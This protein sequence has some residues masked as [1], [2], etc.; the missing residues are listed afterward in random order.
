M[1]NAKGRTAKQMAYDARRAQMRQDAAQAQGPD[2]SGAEVSDETLG[3]GVPDIAD[4]TSSPAF[5]TAVADAVRAAMAERP[6]AGQSAA[7]YADFMSN[8]RQLT[9]AFQVQSPGFNKPLPPEE[10]AR[11]SA[12][13]ET[14]FRL[15]VEAAEAV[16]NFGRQ[17]AAKR[18]LV[19]EYLVGSGGILADTDQ[20]EQMFSPGQRLFYTQAPPKDFLPLNMPAGEIMHAQFQWLGMPTPG[21]EALVNSAVITANGGDPNAEDQKR[22]NR[23][24][25]FAEVVPDSGI[26]SVGPRRIL[27]AT[28]EE[29]SDNGRGR[30]AITKGQVGRPVTGPVFA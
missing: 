5:R 12:G 1:A 9:E 19:P 8:M 26:V 25:Q 7:D 18:D 21:A 10:V 29:S 17:G 28:V 14:F 15:I 20:G 16:E 27:G 24:S 6:P 11:R 3:V 4:I 22:A 2:F 23:N 13:R 30:F